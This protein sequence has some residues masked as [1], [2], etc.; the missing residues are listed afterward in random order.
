MEQPEKTTVIAH[1]GGAELFLENTLSAFKKAEELGV[2]AIECDVHL[3]KDG[4]L[5]VAHDPDLNRIA[6]ID[7]NIA[8]MT[9]A[10]I[11]R[12]ELK[13]GEHIPTLDKVL[14]SVKIPLVVELKN[15]STVTEIV[16]LFKTHPEYIKKV[17]IICFDHRPLLFLKETF[18]EVATGALLAG[19]P[20]DPV[21]VAKACKTDTLSLYYEGLGKEYVD[22]CHASGI[23]VSVWTPNTEKD[24]RDMLNAGVDAIASDR[25]DIVLKMVGRRESSFKM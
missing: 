13:G 7:Q 20:I 5:V 1:R 15:R 19:Y 25:P 8:E 21:A 18:P 23:K 10:E 11:S 16:K 14:D 4:Y 3:T 17:V 22:M 24:I 9:L 6:G 12:I 2:D